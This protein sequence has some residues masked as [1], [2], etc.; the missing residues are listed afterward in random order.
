ME[1]TN[2][3][4]ALTM[5]MTIGCSGANS[6]SG[7][8]DTDNSGP[9]GQTV[10][11]QTTHVGSFVIEDQEDVNYID[12]Y[13]VITG[14][15]TVKTETLVTFQL[16]LLKR[17][18][19]R[20]LL[21]GNNEVLEH[22]FMPALTT[23]GMEV[24]IWNN[25]SLKHLDGLSAL[26]SVGE[27]LNISHHENLTSI[28]GLALLETIG[29]DFNILHNESLSFM[30][31]FNQL[32]SIG[33]NFNVMDN[34]SLT[35]IRG[36]ENL[37]TVG[38]DFIIVTGDE[39]LSVS[40][41]TSLSSI[42]GSLRI[43]LNAVLNNIEGMNAL[44][45]VGGSFLIVDNPELSTCIALTLRDAVGENS[46]VE[47]IVISG[48]L[49]GCDGEEPVPGD[50]LLA[51]S[52]C[53]EDIQCAAPGTPL[54]LR[55]YKPVADLIFPDADPASAAHFA[56]IG[57]EF[58]GGYCSTEGECVTDSDCG[59]GGSCFVP[60]ENVTAET[61]DE[62]AQGGFPFDIYGF[63]DLGLCLDACTE[64]TEC[65]DGYTC[66]IPIGDLLGLVPGASEQTFCIAPAATGPC[67]DNPCVNGGI[68]VNDTPD[69]YTCDCPPAFTG[70]LCETPA[71][72][73][74]QNPDPE[75]ELSACETNP[76]QN[77]A[78]CTEVDNDYECACLPGFMGATCDALV[79][80]GEPPVVGDASA[81]LAS[82]T[83]ASQVYY[84]C[85]EGFQASDEQ[86]SVLVCAADGQWT[87]TVPTCE[88]IQCDAPQEIA[89][90]SVSYSETGYESLVVYQ[91]D[92]GMLMTPID[93]A[94][95]YCDE[96]G[97]WS[98]VTPTCTIIDC[99]EPA[100]LT[101]GSINQD[102]TTYGSEISYACDEGYLILPVGGATQLCSGD[103]SWHGPTAVCTAVDCGAPPSAPNGNVTYSE[104]G[105]TASATYSCDIG[106]AMGVSDSGERICMANGYWS[107]A[108]PICAI[109]GD[110][111][112]GYIRIDGVCTDIDECATQTS[113]CDALVSCTN[114]DGAFICGAC[115]TGF[116]DAF[117][118]GTQCQDI[119]E[120]ALGS[121]DCSAEVE[122]INTAGS[123][124][125]GG[126]PAGYTDVNGDGTQCVDQNE[127]SLGSDDCDDLV[128]CTN[129]E[130]SFTC[131]ACPE[132]YS[133]VYADGTLCEDIDECITGINHCDLVASCSNIPGSFECACPEGWADT[134]G[135][136]SYCEEPFLGCSFHILTYE[137]TGMFRIAG[138]TFGMGDASFVIPDGS[139]PAQRGVLKIRVSDDGQGN[140]GNG[141][142]GVLYYSMDQVFS[143]TVSGLTTNTNT[144]GTAGTNTN[145]VSLN[146]GSLSGTALTWQT[147]NTSGSGNNWT[148]DNPASGAGCVPNYQ[149][150]GNVE[151]IDNSALAN[152]S[153]GGLQD[154]DNP[155]TESWTQLFKNFSFGDGFNTVT[156]NEA[157]IPNRSPSTTYVE[158]NGTLAFPAEC[159]P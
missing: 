123:F 52:A 29:G 130:G 92:E 154:G 2:W 88:A 77:G 47:E 69:T 159:V 53:E 6:P 68:C 9:N 139:N 58:P 120:C 61:L 119:D 40:G 116:N 55:E 137:L 38:E 45:A 117:A 89:G 36:Y 111:N 35:I 128:S 51:G 158:F 91:C 80:C 30:E 15:L 70:E 4:V 66:D 98:S 12:H 71:G 32:I 44:E 25:R 122:C 103:G 121:D 115:P 96:N 56:G 144:N 100:A 41:F 134:L 133:D 8:E 138:T 90:G 114:T 110:C 87:G 26:Q 42:G 93:G 1:W 7:H 16:P 22:F 125:C 65:R 85:D 113:N 78:T 21:T 106:F 79:D 46:V 82:T 146:A 19:G 50:G 57:L 131:G 60:F 84:E 3:L 104:T 124:T 86:A 148:P 5:A 135:D 147:C 108:A 10:Y 126:C 48:N 145:T 17:I 63:A 62:L 152:C 112:P 11:E 150:S 43:A 95:R 64:S 105:Y 94:I 20:L 67:L 118:D 34:D 59:A 28:D 23:V 74:P 101:H 37:L 151:C 157:P 13:I 140:P 39:L 143:S 149:S 18:H 155:Q 72:D 99:G 24:N 27:N 142:A 83:Y 76:C 14:D 109:L 49:P 153:T 102:T 132:G 97:N 31:D 129:T 136:G 156:M 107:G 127:C 54:C 81:F 33:G 141:D 75:E 73:E